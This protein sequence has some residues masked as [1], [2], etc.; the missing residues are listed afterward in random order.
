LSASDTVDR[1]GDRLE[2]QPEHP[3]DGRGDRGTDVTCEREEGVTRS[4]DEPNA[5]PDAAV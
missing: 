1:D 2:P 4:R 3:L 5:D